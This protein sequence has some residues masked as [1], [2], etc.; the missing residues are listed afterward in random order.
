[1]PT[2]AGLSV[3]R[4]VSTQPTRQIFGSQPAISSSRSFARFGARFADAATATKPS[5]RI[6]GGT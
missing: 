3:A 4:K 2:S 1:M 5:S 6:P